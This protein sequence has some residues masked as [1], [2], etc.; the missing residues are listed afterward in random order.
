MCHIR[1]SIHDERLNI[2]QVISSLETTDPSL[3]REVQQRWKLCQGVNRQLLQQLDQVEHLSGFMG[4]HGF[5]GV[6]QGGQST[7]AP[8]S[9]LILSGES[10]DAANII[11]NEDDVAASGK[12][13]NGDV[14]R[15]ME[16]I[17]SIVE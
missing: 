4:Q 11:S 13:F 3:C 5:V 1:T 17:H 10:T 2:E 7:R 14:E 15:L 8:S 6:R 9:T 16:F 12:E